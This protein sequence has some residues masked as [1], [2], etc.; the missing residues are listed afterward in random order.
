[1]TF[2]VRKITLPGPLFQCTYNTGYN[3]LHLG[4]TADTAARFVKALRVITAPLAISAEH[5]FPVAPL[6]YTSSILPDRQLVSS[7]ANHRR[8]LALQVDAA[9]LR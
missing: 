8:R 3:T 1:M 7:P 6:R 5:S 4:V 9:K 2:L